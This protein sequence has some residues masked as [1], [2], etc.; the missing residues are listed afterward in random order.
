LFC[1]NHLG[2]AVSPRKVSPSATKH[3]HMSHNYGGNDEFLLLCYSST[4]LE[5]F[6]QAIAN[7]TVTNPTVVSVSRSTP[8]GSCTN[9]FLGV[10]GGLVIDS[11]R[12]SGGEDADPPVS[13]VWRTDRLACWLLINSVSSGVSLVMFVFSSNPARPLS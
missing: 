11:S 6:H 2:L 10:E 12:L 5:T 8:I 4:S 7:I 13:A 1:M 3:L 9:S